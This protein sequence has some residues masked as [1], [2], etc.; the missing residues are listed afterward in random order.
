LRH[1]SFRAPIHLSKPHLDAGALVVNVVNPTAGLLAGDRIRYDVQVESGARLML[2]APSAN[3]VHQ[4]RD[5]DAE[6]CQEFRVAERGYLE[7]WPELMIPQAGS[8]Y[9][10]QTVIR[11]ESGG[12]L[13]FIE[14]LAPGRVASGEVFR[15]TE[16][17]WAT[18]LWLG[19]VQLARERYVLT[20]ENGSL[21]PLRQHFPTGYYASIFIVAAR[22]SSTAECW[23]R[24]HELHDESAWI[25]VSSL[26]AGSFIVKLLARD[27]LALR[28]K[29][30]CIRGLIYT[31]F[32][33]ELPSIRRV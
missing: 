1:Q 7:S 21:A 13:L 11:I 33:R 12:E 5:H 31:A 29:L 24:I 10:Q 8:R 20:P 26:G 23:T 9:R 30:S 18:D 32:G 15:F 4:M 17:T 14:T 27:S 25:G 22:L 2:T 6:V 3:R 16:L 28:K 19:D